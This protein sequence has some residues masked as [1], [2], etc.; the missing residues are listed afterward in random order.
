[1]S[2]PPPTG[3]AGDSSPYISSGMSL[4]SSSPIQ[5]VVQHRPE[6]SWTPGMEMR[7]NLGKE[8]A[9]GPADPAGS[10][11]PPSPTGCY[12]DSGW[13]E[14]TEHPRE[15]QLSLQGAP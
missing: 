12:R 3:A 13:S 4:S 6:S 5:Q 1:M 2:P 11:R 14:A 10:L 7:R 9:K 8:V 15:P